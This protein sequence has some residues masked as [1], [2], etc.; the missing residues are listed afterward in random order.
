M[1]LSPWPRRKRAVAFLLLTLLAGSGVSCSGERVRLYPVRGQIL[2][3]GRPVDRAVV[4]FHPL[5]EQPSGAQKPIAYTD[6]DGRFSLTTD[7]PGDGA[8]AGEYAITVELREKTQTGVEKVHGRNLLPARYSKPESSG[9]RWRVQE[10]PNE[11]PPF[12]LTDR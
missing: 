12:N 7:R 1:G 11:P 3:K 5:D 4:V 9:L 6:A 8:S 10:G 2:Y